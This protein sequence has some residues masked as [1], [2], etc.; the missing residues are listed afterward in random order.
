MRKLTAALL[1]TIL[2]V[3]PGARA[4]PLLLVMD[5]GSDAVGAIAPFLAPADRHGWIVS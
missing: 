2:T 5:P 1:A 3:G 4:W